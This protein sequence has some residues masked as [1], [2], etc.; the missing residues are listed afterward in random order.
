MIR[1]LLHTL[2]APTRA[3]QLDGEEADAAKDA[4]VAAR[5]RGAGLRGPVPRLD[6]AA[7]S[8]VYK[9]DVYA[10]PLP[11]ADDGAA[12]ARCGLALL[13][14]R[15]APPCIEGLTYGC[16]PGAGATM[17]VRLGCRGRFGC[18]AATITCGLAGG[19]AAR[20]VLCRC[21]G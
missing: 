16:V 6:G 14:Q 8:L 21:E 3:S 10:R 2:T 20:T 7:G 11:D 15:S 4:R 12:A 5:L 9:S 13:E 19:D 1:A 18:G 17:W